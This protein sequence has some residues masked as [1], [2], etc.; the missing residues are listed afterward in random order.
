MKEVNAGKSTSNAVISA[1]PSQKSFGLKKSLKN[2]KKSS[3]VHK[4]SSRKT[5]IH[6]IQQP[7]QISGWA[8]NH[9][10]LQVKTESGKSTSELKA[11]SATGLYNDGN[12]KKAR[13][14]EA[15]KHDSSLVVAEVKPF[16]EVTKKRPISAKQIKEQAQQDQQ[17]KRLLG[18]QKQQP[19]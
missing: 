15:T 11:Q 4:I 6:A 17:H 7:D 2:S 3:S 10:E 19:S 12:L 8:K 9:S 5:S 14:S 16:N 1:R 18:K 13:F